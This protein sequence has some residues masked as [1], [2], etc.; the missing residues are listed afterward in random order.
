[1]IRQT[2]DDYGFRT[3]FELWSVNPDPPVF[4]GTVKIGREGMDGSFG[5][6]IARTPLEDSFPDLDERYMSLGQDASY[7]ERI[8]EQLGA[9]D[10]RAVLSALQDLTLDLDRLQRS[11]FE[12]ERVLRKSIMRVVKWTTVQDQYRRIV[13]GGMPREAF[14]LTYSHEPDRGAESPTTTFDVS[15]GDTVPGTLQVVIGS[16]GA[17]KTRMLKNISRALDPAT[18]TNPSHVHVSDGKRLSGLVTVS[19]SA[20]DIFPPRDEPADEFSPFQIKHLGL[21]VLSREEGGSSRERDGAAQV[22]AFH[23]LVGACESAGRSDRLLKAV[24]T[25]CEADLILGEYDLNSVA[26]L[27]TLGFEELSSGHKIVLLTAAGLVKN[28]DEATLILLDEPESHLHPPLLSAFMRA[29]G[30]LV[31]ETNSLA[32]VATHS[33]VVLQQVPRRHAR[34]IWRRGIRTQFLP[35]SIETFGENLGT[36]SREVFGVELERSGHYALLLRAVDQ[37]NYDEAV[38]ALG[39]SIGEEAKMILRALLAERAEVF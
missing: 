10:G 29:V 28:C 17:G 21:S 18:E 30:D 14:T 31:A 6:P 32:I 8:F 5:G 26:S 13:L 22:A 1:M 37:G 24:S 33:P 9:E 36:L 7:Y 23:D 35:M 2:W 20:F 15:P 27:M 4:L 12:F 25:L 34:K 19:F 39:G 11:G 38:G 16:N 3:S